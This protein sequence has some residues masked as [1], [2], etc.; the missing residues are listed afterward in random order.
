[1]AD[2]ACFVE[3]KR[4]GA[5]F[6]QQWGETN[7]VASVN[8]LETAFAGAPPKANAEISTPVS[9][10]RLSLGDMAL[11]T[12]FFYGL[13]DITHFKIGFPERLTGDIKGG[14]KTFFRG[15]RRQNKFFGGDFLCCRS[16]S[17]P[18]S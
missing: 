5:I 10:T 11:F 4:S 13:L 3:R 15:K 9:I 14:F 12:Y 8:A 18:R 6:F 17:V 7:M 2:F 16:H 1:M